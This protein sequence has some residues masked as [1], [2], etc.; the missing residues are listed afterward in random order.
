MAAGHDPSPFVNSYTLPM[1]DPA[2]TFAGPGYAASPPGTSGLAIAALLLGCLGVLTYVPAVA[3]VI[4]GVLA[5]R[6]IRRTNAG[7][8]GVATSGLVISSIAALGWTTLLVSF[9]VT[10]A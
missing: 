8:V 4:C 5:L 1:P 2:H 9:W 10:G 6:H 7:G 3:G